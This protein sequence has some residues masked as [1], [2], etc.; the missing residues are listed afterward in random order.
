MTPKNTTT[1]LLGLSTLLIGLLASTPFPARADDRDFLKI[2]GGNPYLFILLD[3]SASMSLAM[4]GEDLPTAGH[5][6]DPDS[7]LYQAKS[8]LFSVFE[9]LDEVNFGFATFNQDHLRIVAKHYNYYASD[10]PVGTWPSDLGWPTA[11]ADGLTEYVDSIDVDSDGD[12]V[13]DTS[14]GYPDAWANDVEGDALVFGPLITENGSSVVEVG[15]CN[16]P[17]DISTDFDRGRLN[18]LSKLGVDGDETVG[19]W[20]RNGGRSATTYYLEFIPVAGVPGD[21]HLTVG[22]AL[23]TAGTCSDTEPPTGTD[24]C[25]NGICEPGED[26]LNCSADCAGQTTGRPSGRFCCANESDGGDYAVDCYADNR[27]SY[28]GYTCGDS[29]EPIDPGTDFGIGSDYYAT[30]DLTLDERIGE[31][32]MIDDS[33]SN[34]NETEYQQGY[35]QYSDVQHDATCGS[36]SPHAGLGWEGNY[37]GSVVVSGDPDTS[38]SDPFCI[39][40]YCLDLKRNPTTLSAIDRTLDRGDMLPFDWTIDNKTEFLQRLSPS[41]P[42]DGVPDFRVVSHLSDMKDLDTD[43]YGAAIASRPP[44]I[45]SGNTPIANAIVDFRCWYLGVDGSPSRSDCSSTAF[46]SRGWSGQACGSD[47]EYGCRKPFLVIIT[48]GDDTC[49]GNNP[50]GD[51]S[52]LENFTGIQ[53]WVLNV[54]NERN[55]K[56]GDVSAWTSSGGLCVDVASKQQMIEELNEIVGL[57]Q[58]SSR[59]FS[60]AAVPSVQLNSD[61]TI[62]LTSFL[63]INN[64]SIWNGHFDA[65]KKPAP[66]TIDRTHPNH[67]WDAGEVLLA[68][69]YDASDPLD[70]T[71]ASKRR[72]FYFHESSG[73]A[74]GHRRLLDPTTASDSDTTRYELWRSFGF[75][76]SDTSDSAL[77]DDLEL[78]IEAQANGTISKIFTKKTATLLDNS[79][80]DYL[81][82][83][84]FHSNPLVVSNPPNTR[85]FAEDVGADQDKNCSA[86]DSSGSANRGYRCFF[87]RHR[88]RRKV[89]MMGANDGMV[90]AFNVARFASGRFDNGTG[91]ELWGYMPRAVM[92]TVKLQVSGT[93]HLLSVDGTLAA[94]D[95]FIDPLHTGVPSESDRLWRT[96]TIG[97]LREGGSAYFAFDVTQPD[98]LTTNAEGAF[99]P[100]GGSDAVPGCVNGGSNCGPV[101]YPTALWEFHDYN[102]DSIPIGLAPTSSVRLDEDGNG[103]ADLGDTWSVPNIGRILVCSESATNCKSN[104]DLE[105]KYVAIFGGGMDP[106]NKSFDP[107]D[108]L[109]LASHSLTGNWLYIVDIELGKV[110]YKRELAGAAPASPAAI[111]ADQDGYI[112]RIY[113]PT[114][115]G[116]VYRVDLGSDDS[117]EYPSLETVTVS[118]LNNDPLDVKRIATNGAGDSV[119]EPTIIFDANWDGN[120]RS[121]MP[122]PLYF[123]PSVVLVSQLG[124]YALSLGTGDR[125]DLWAENSQ[126]GRYFVFVDDTDLLDPSDSSTFPLREELFA[127]IAPDDSELASDLLTSRNIGTRGW[128]LVLDENEKVITDGVTISGVS[129]FGSFQPTVEIT[130]TQ[131]DPVGNQSPQCGDKK[132][133]ADV[134]NSCSKQGSSNLFVVNTTNGNG[135]IASDSDTFDRYTVVD[136]MVSNPFTEQAQ[137]ASGDPETGTDETS[138]ELTE[139]EAEIME[140]LKDLFPEN[141]KFANFRIDIKTITSDSQIARI[142]PVPICLIER[143]WK[144][145]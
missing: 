23:T 101:P 15:S 118:D 68:Q 113:Q 93:S 36:D 13:A 87:E 121:A 141:C 78:Q 26:C 134:S 119:W 139:Q 48:D 17:L 9:G 137:N 91:H 4:G 8:A 47:P 66:I 11:D 62:Y 69:Q 120:V 131:G 30:L 140:K 60:S 135:L 144:E 125:E 106:A 103:V 42:D 53:T 81:F 38:D 10:A 104:G 40:D 83:D 114:I 102:T 43:T 107:N 79:T 28:A 77:D 25:G 64:Q 37:D 111:D 59:T 2:N 75:I 56:S 31:F 80:V 74:G 117:G 19:A 116:L 65:F 6:D 82:G 128:Y 29:P 22:L 96:V 133:E 35:W 109:Q 88:Y 61:Q 126:S 41:Y 85:Y 55:C 72:V 50:N 90:H 143:N 57:I 92:P 115:S 27:C 32:L 46:S 58:E 14:D 52:A 76:S 49:P 21:P 99:V 39:G 1:K 84:V 110:I 98:P 20:V 95:T 94:G 105:E 51:L 45:A 16:D 100:T 67:L 54:G 73:L 34:G 138:D 63:P 129:V 3:N 24:S 70:L 33:N 18:T 124:L 142:A 145:Y 136:A 122:R 132:Y 89:A 44:V 97:G 127:E 130:D 108:P 86:D 71:A 123:Q 112:D 12:G 5:G 7:R